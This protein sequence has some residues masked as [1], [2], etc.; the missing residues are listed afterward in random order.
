M[1]HSHARNSKGFTLIELLVVMIMIGILSA[2]AAPSFLGLLNRNRISNTTIRLKS[3]LVE[4]Q[5]NSSR[6]GK[7]CTVSVAATNPVA[8]TT[9]AG[10]CWRTGSDTFSGV[11]F[12]GS[13]SSGVKLRIV[14]ATSPLSIGFDFKGRV[15]TPTSATST[16]VISLPNTTD[17]QGY[18]RCVNISYPLGIV[19]IGTY[20]SNACD[21]DP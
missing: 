3:A 21:I 7:P 10:N 1:L 18:E 15:N 5:V 11:S 8:S 16:I 2:I 14:G 13:A 4:A 12:S 17:G 19:N 20:T 9:L 6:T